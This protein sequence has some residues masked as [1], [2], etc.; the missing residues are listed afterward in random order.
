MYYLMEP[1]QALGYNI[2]HPWL[3]NYGLWRSKSGGSVD[4]EG[5]IYLWYDASKKST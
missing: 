4:Q 3:Q 1:G 5:N 2:M